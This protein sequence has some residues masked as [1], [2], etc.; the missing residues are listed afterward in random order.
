M[1]ASHYYTVLSKIEVLK[2]IAGDD[3]GVIAVFTIRKV[4]IIGLAFASPIILC[5]LN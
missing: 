1:N 3:A 2:S 4:K 5:Y